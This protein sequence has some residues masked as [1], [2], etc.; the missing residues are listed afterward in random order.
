MNAQ[1]L[2]VITANYEVTS[3]VRTAL[4]A[5][6]YT[7]Q[8]AYSHRDALYAV[9]H[10]HYDAL[11]VDRS[12]TDR[13]SG[14]NTLAALLNGPK[15]PPII[16][17]DAF[18]GTQEI[19]GAQ[20][21]LH[22]LEVDAI[23]KGVRDIL[24]PPT[25]PFEDFFTELALTREQVEPNADTGHLWKREEVQTLFALSRSLTEVLDLNEVLTRVVDAARSLTQADEGMIL[26]PDGESGELYLRAK[27]GIDFDVA[28]NFR[29]KT[30]DTLAGKV[31]RD[32]V[33]VLVGARGPQKVKTE[34]FVNSLLYVPILLKGQPIG[35]LGVNNKT[36][37]D[38]FTL[39]DQELLSSLASYAAI[40]IENARIHGQSVKRARELKA[41]VDA[42]QTI[43]ASL[44][45]EH[46]LPTICTQVL[47]VLDAS[48]AE[49]YE[50][51]PDTRTLRLWARR[52]NM[53]WRMNAEP[54]LP[55]EPRPALRAALENRLP[56]LLKRD[57]SGKL[58]E[59]LALG[60]LG[61]AAQMIIPIVTGG[62][63][64]GVVLAYYRAAPDAIEKE[65]LNRVQAMSIEVFSMLAEGKV[66]TQGALPN[67]AQ[68]VKE[69]LR[70]DW[71]EFGIVA[72]DKSAVLIRYSIGSSVWQ[73][74]GSPTLQ[75][76]DLPLLTPLFE[77]QTAVT[78]AADE[79]ADKK[80]LLDMFRCKSIL[81]LP[82][83]YR[84]A[85]QGI[86]VAGDTMQAQT[87]D[88]REVDLCRAIV[89]QACTALENARL[90][91]DLELSLQE[92]RDTQARLIQTARLSA[93]GELA[94]AV[95]HQINN[96]L[97]TIVLD[98][99]LL[100]DNPQLGPS[101]RET[102]EAISKAGKR[103]ASVVRRLLASVRPTSQNVLPPEPVNVQYTIEETLALVRAHIERD[104]IRIILRMPPTQVPLVMAVPGE[105]DD[106]WL[107]LLLN[108]HDALVG[109]PNAEIGI[110]LNYEPESDFLTV[111]VWDNGPGIP[112]AMVNDIF[113]PFFT[114]KPVGEGTGLGLHICRQV[115]DRV[116]G[117]ISVESSPTMGTSFIV[118]LPVTRREE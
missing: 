75:L 22:T 99:E 103:A 98:T 31:Y 29:V 30:K 10:A 65:V 78:F 17:Y 102:L 63:I 2:L 108:A 86:V 64:L 20:A 110:E 97:T 28:R 23:L 47:N 93:M 95:A 88:A 19:H 91:H 100:L 79:N 77:T 118:R 44:A 48:L 1:R 53:L 46:M 69:T 73:D 36:K 43:N 87:F 94:A 115:I 112:E 72:P 11:L 15:C 111:V 55:L 82:L 4:E 57:S 25:E 13:R 109:R 41:L 9:G 16:A 54:S 39:R 18:N 33:P 106:V 56:L 89:G 6:G 60:Q 68:A 27:V 8:G 14:Q 35:V 12:M 76:D 74:E 52:A 85:V 40:A 117:Q 34:Y 67:K 32:G 81:A 42:S 24:G 84:G 113:K 101:D 71:C 5:R 51:Q 116:G 61:A 50:F 90:L 37:D 3:T 80:K 7:V 83:Y 105:L 96:P 26:L 59:K 49:I 92:L 66:S 58:E 107:N 62:Q 114:T 45:L 38:L 70:C 21:T 104:N